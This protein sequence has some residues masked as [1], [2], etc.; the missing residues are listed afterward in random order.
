MRLITC[1]RS[2][3]QNEEELKFI[4]IPQKFW[5]YIDHDDLCF[6]DGCDIV[7]EKKESNQYH[8]YVWQKYGWFTDVWK[9]F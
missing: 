4:T 1:L 3:R 7:L 9:S 5:P 2:F 8:L 6:K